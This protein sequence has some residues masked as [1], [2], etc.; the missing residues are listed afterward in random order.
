MLNLIVAENGEKNSKKCGLDG[1]IIQ[2]KSENPVRLVIKD[3]QITIEDASDLWG[4]DTFEVDELLKKEFGR[5]ARSVCIGIAG[6]KLV[7]IAAIMN[8]GEVGRAAGRAGVGAV[9]GSKNLKP[10]LF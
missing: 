9:M 3:D 2:G 7:K 5:N 10:S 6:E 4:K 1:M 8:E